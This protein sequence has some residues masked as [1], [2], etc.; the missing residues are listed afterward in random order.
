MATIIGG[1]GNGTLNSSLYTLN[2]NDTTGAGSAGNGEQVY[3]NVTNGN[4]VIDHLDQFLPSETNNFLTLRTYNSRGQFATPDGEGWDLTEF[5]RLSVITPGQVVLTNGDGSQFNFFFDPSS[6]VY[7]STDGAGA[8]E[9]LSFNPRNGTYSVVLSNQTVVTYDFTGRLIQSK[10]TNGNTITY[11][12]NFGGQLTSIADNDGHQLSFIYNFLGQLTKIQDETNT[13]FASYQYSGNELTSV[14]DRAGATTHY[15]YWPDGTLR[16]VTL[17]STAGEAQ[18]TLQFTYFI[19]PGGPVIASFTDA[20]GN[21]TRFNYDFNVDI[22]GGIEGGTTFVTNAAGKVTAYSFDVNGNITD[23]QDAQGLDTVYGYDSNNNLTTVIDANGSGIVRSDSAYYRN[24]R[25]SFGVVDASGQ[26]KLVWQLTFADIRN[27]QAHFTTHLTYDNNGNLTSQTDASG[28]LTTYTYTGFNK[29]ASST[30]AEGNALLTSNDPLSV[31]KRQEL[32]FV[33]PATGLGKSVAQLTTADRQAIRALYTTVYSYD[34]HQNLTQIK[35]AGGDLT[36]LTYDAFGNLSTKTVYLDSTNLTDP[37]KQETTQYFYDAFGNNIKTIDAQGNT[38][39]STFDHF[40]NKLTQVD[41]NGGVTRNTYDNENRLT[42]TTDPL[43]NTT[44]NFY[45]AVGNRIA[46]Q[47]ASGHTVTY[48]Y[49]SDNLLISTIDPSA[50]ASQAVTRT[51]VTNYAYDVM[52]N[53]TSSTDANGNTTTY[54]YDALNRMVTVTTPRVANAAGNSVNYTTSYAYDGVGNR[55]SVIDNNGNRTDTVYNSNNLVRQVTDASGNITQFAYDADLNQ[56]SIVVGAQLGATARQILKFDYD[57]KDRLISDTDALGNTNRIA[58]D[59]ANNRVS[60]TDANGNTTNYTYDRDNR[61]LTETKPAVA[62]P[63]TGQP[64]RYTIQHQY[65]A[66]GNQIAVTDQDGHT[67]RMSFD[68]DNRAVLVQ[69]ANGIQTVYTFDSRGNR[70][71]VQVGVQAHVSAAGTVVVDSTQSAQVETFTYDEFNQIVSK[72]D[73][74]GN[75]LISSDSALYVQM[76]Q[77]LGVVDPATGKG[78]LVAQLTAADIQTLKAQFTEVYTYDRV[79]NYTSTTDHLGRTTSLTYDALN[80]LVK[81]TDA[82]GQT[83]KTAFD[84]D[85]NVVSRTDALGRKT[86]NAYDS[87][88]RLV[89]T[90]DALGV[91][92][93]RTYD[94]FGN[95]TSTTAANGTPDARTTRYVYDLDNRLIANTDALGN[96]QTYSYDAVGNRLKVTDAKGQTTRYVYDALNRNIAIIDPLGLQTRFVY[97]GVGNRLSLVDAKGGIT[98]FTY[99]AG[100]R[101]IQMTDAMGRVTTFAYDVRGN[102]ISQT[103]ASGTSAQETTTYL[104]DAENHLRQVTDAAGGVTLEGY[105]ADY[106]RTSV[107]DAN[108]H[109]TS[110]KF[111]ALNREIQVTDATGAVTKYSYDAVG[112]RLSVTDGNGHVTTYAYDARNELISATDATGVVTTYAYDSVGNQVRITRAANTSAAAT[113]TFAYDLDNRLTAQTDAVGDTQT[114]RYDADGNLVAT[115][116]AL[117]HATTYA[118][119]A[120]NRVTSITDP[121]GNVTQYRYDA[122]GNRVQVIDARGFVSTNYYDADNEVALSVDNDG[123]A[124]SF[125]YDANGNII[126][127]TLYATALTLPLDPA[128]QPTPVTSS[129]LDQ[130]TL[131]AYDQLNRL[132]SRTDGDGFVT[133]Y[134]Y[135]A[136]GNRIATRQALDLAGTQFEVTRAFYDAVNREVASVTAQGYLTT[137]SYDAAGNRVSQTQ[138][139]QIVSVPANGGVPQPVSGDT[140]RTTTFAYDA[141]N[142]LVRQTDALGVV[143]TYQYDA[144][145]N[146]VAMTL[147]AGTAAAATTTYRY[148]AA[149]RNIETTNALGVVTHFDLDANGNVLKRH[150]AYG[151]AQE[152]VSSFQYDANNRVISTTDPL[153][154]VTR[155]A[156][157]S[158]GNLVSRTVGNGTATAETTTYSYDGDERQVSTTD[159]AG[160]A[161]AAVYNAAGEQVQVTQAVGL[162]DARTTSF[163]YDRANRLVSTT[164]AVG[165]VTQYQYDGAGNQVLV[166]QAAGTTQQRQSSFAYDLDNRLVQTTDPMGGVTQ[167]QYNA[168]GNQTRV[169]DANGGVQVNTFDAMGRELSSLS[170]GGILTRNTYDQ[171]GNLVSTTQSL[172]DGSDART[173][174]FVYDALN[175]QIQA[176]DGGGF[177][178]SFVYDAFGNRTSMTDARGNTTAY[179]YDADNRLVSMTDALGN[180]TSYQY[181]AIGNRIRTTD[182]NG[183]STSYAYDLLN[184]LVQTT[185]ADGGVTRYTYDHVGNRIAQDQQQSGSVFEHTSYQY[186]ADGRLISQTDPVGSVTQYTYDAVGN[187]LSQTS[188]AGTSAARTVH[189]EYDLD[190][191]KIA[192]VDALGNRTTYAYDAVGNRIS[193]TDPLGHVTHNYYDGANRL[194]EAVDPLGFI[195]SYAYDAASN[196]IRTDVYMTAVSGSIDARVPPSPPAGSPDQVTTQQYDRADRL[197]SQ[198]AADGTVTRYTYDAVGNRTSMTDARGNTTSYAY[199]ADNRLVTQTDATGAVT[200]YTYDAVGNRLSVT[201]A[202]GHV[203]ASTYD[204]WNKLISSTDANGVVTTYAYDLLGNQVQVTRAAG[205]SAAS[206]KTYA[207]DLDNRLVSQTDALGDTQT[208][209]Y[210]AAG[211]LVA[212]TDAL[213]HTTTYTYDANGQV[214][215]V[216]DPVGNVTQYRYDAAGNRA[217][218]IDAR[219]FVSTSYYNA[220]NELVLSVDNAG[221]ATGYV[222][223]ANGNVLSSTLYATALTLPLNPAVQPTPVTSASSDQT[224]LFAYDPLN[225][226]V[227]RTDGDGFVTQYVYD[228]VGNRIATRQALDLAATQF[229]VTRAYYDAVNRE[230][231]SVTAQGYLTTY[232]YDAA[233]NRVSQT[234]CDQ[235]VSVPANGSVPQ[236][237]SGD[238]GRTTTFAYDADNRLVQQTDALGVVTTYQYDARGNRISMTQ[239]AG[240]SQAATTTYRY[241]AADRYIETTN[242]LGVVT[243]FDLDANGNVLK[244]HDAYGT[245]QERVSS[246]QYDA[247]NR[248]VSQTDPRNVATKTTYDGDGNVVSTTV[249]VGTASAETTAFAYDGDNREIATT[250]AT[251]GTTTYAYDAAGNQVRI[252]QTT[253]LGESRTNT[254]VYDRWNRLISA[255]DAVGTVTQ[256]QYDGAGNKILTTQA[257]GTAQQRQ[258]FYAYD[259]DNRL[260]QVTDPMGGVTHY[261]YDAQGN[262]TRIVDAN[263]GVQINTFDAMGHVLSS[264]SAGGILTRNTVDLRGN[265][266]STTQSLADGSDARTSTYAYDAL[267]QQVEVTDGEGFSTSIGYDAF[268]NQVSITHGQYLVSPSDPAYSATKAAQAFPQTSTFTYDARNHMLSMTD[269]L[270]NVT[271]YQYD[272]IGNRISTTDAN[273]HTT[274]YAYDSLNRLVQTTTPAGGVTRYAYDHVG[275]K[276]DQYQLQSGDPASGVWEHTSYQYDSNGHVTGQTDPTGSVTQFQYDALGNQLSK[277]SAAGTSDARTV[278]MEYDLDNRKTADVDALGNRTTYAYDAV[279]NRIKVTDALG[280]VAHYY[281]DGADQLT[282]LVDAQGNVNTFAYD[283]AGNQVQTRVYMTAF[284]GSISEGV[285]PAPAA[286]SQDRITTQQYDRANRLVAQTAADGSL[287]QYAYDAAGNKVSEIQFANT[288]APRTLRFAYDADDRLVTFTDVDGSVTTFTYDKANN[289]TSQTITSASDPNHLRTTTYAYDADNHEQSETFDPSKLALTQSFAYDRL[290]NVTSKTD[291]DGHTTTLAYDLNNRVVSQ[292]DPLGNTTTFTYDRVGNKIAVTDARQNTTNFVYD[293]NNRL[294]EAIL[295]AVQIFTVSGGSQTVRPTTLHTYDANGNEVRT[296]VGSYTTLVNG[297][298][299]TVSGNVTTRYFDGNNRLIG[300]VDATNAFTTYTYDAAGDKTSQTLYMTRLGASADPSTLPSAPA[301]DTQLITYAYDLMG[302]LTLTTYPAAKITTLINANTSNPSTTTVTKQVTERNVYDAFGNLV[303]A[304]D[305]NGNA[306]LVYY[307]VK[308]RKIAVVDGAG[309]LSEWDYDEQGNV[310]EQR[311]YTQP[312][313]ISTLQAGGTPPTPPSG[314]VYTTDFQYDAASRK[315][316]ETDPQIATFDPNS[317]TTTQL[318]PTT[319]YTYDKVGN[320]LTKTLG[321]G[322]AQAVTEYSYYDADNRQIATIDSGRVLSI[323]SYDASGNVVAQRRYFNPVGSG[324]DLTQLNGTTN[325]AALVSADSNRDEETEFAFDA[326]NRATQQSDLLSSGTL[327]K[328]FG[329]DAVS[330]RTYTQDEDHFI[331]RASFDGMNRLVESISADNSGTQYEYDAAG[332]RV[333]AY[334]GVF[335]GG[336]PA[337]AQ[338]SSASLGS[339]VQVTWTT[340]ATTTSPLQTWVVYD[341]SSHQGLSG[342]ANRTAAQVS[343]N[344]QSLTAALN[345]AGTSGTIYFRVVTVDGAGNET[346]TEEQSLSVPPRF[347]AVSVSQPDASTIVVTAHFDAGAVSPQLVYGTSGHLSQSVAFVLQSDGSYQVTLSGLSNPGDLSF[348]LKW[349]D[350]A[351]NEYLSSVSSFA[352]VADQ[353]A[354]SSTISQS[355]IVSGSNTSYT[356]SVS[357]QVPAGYAAGLTSMQAKWRSGNGVFA[358]T[359]VSGTSSGQ[360]TVIFNAV[361]G[362][363]NNLAPGTYEIVLTGVR[364]DGTTVEL[365]HFTY[366]VSPTA[367]TVTRHAVSWIA[368][369][370]GNDQLVIIDGQNAPSTRDG[371]RVVATDGVTGASNDYAAYYGQD[372]SDSHTVDVTS[373]AHTTSSPDPKNP[374]GPPIVTTTGYDV[375]VQATLSAGELANIGSGGLHLAWRPAGSGT[376]FSNDSALTGSGNT[377]STTLGN[378][379]AGQYD[380]KIYYVDAQGHQVIVEWQRIDTAAANNVYSGHSLTILA[381]ETGGTI[382]TDA[383]GVIALHPGVYTGALNV[384]ALSSALS[385]VHTKTGQAGGSLTTDGRDTGYFTQYEYNAL[386]EKTASNEGDGLWRTFGVDGNGNVVETDLRGDH[387]NTNAIVTYTAYDARNRKVADFGAPVVGPDGTT[388]VRPVTRYAYNVQDKV[389][390][391]TDALN[392]TTRYVY[393]AL[394]TQIET[395]D[396]YG[397]TT[398]TLVDQFGNVT[399]TVT[400]LGHRSLKFYDLQGRLVKEQ[401]AMGNATTYTYDAFGRRLT[402]T[403]A[404]GNTSSYTYDQRDR[405]TS[406]TDP[407]NNTESFAY[408]GRNNRISTLYP[409]GQRTDQ[410]YD[411]LGRVIDT[412]VYLNGQQAHSQ[413]AYDAYGNLISETDA[414]LR[415]KTHVYGAFG[416]LMEDIDEDGNVIAYNYDVYGRK[417]RSFDPSGGKDIQTTYNQ[418]GQITSVTDLA[419]HVSTTYTYDLLGHR[420]SE[421][422]TTPVADADRNTTYEYDALG[423]L[424]RW[425]DS[426][427]HDNLNTQFDAEGNVAR[428]YTDNGYDPLSQNPDAN[429]N[430][431]YVDH[432]YTYDADRRLVQEVQRTT[433]ASGNT[434]DSILN[435]Y[436]YDAAS[437][438]STWNHDS[439]VVTYTYDA[440]GRVQEGDYYTGSDLNQQQW[441]YDAMGNVLTYTTLKDGALQTQTVNTYN[442]ENRS[443]TSSSTSDGKTQVTT[444]TYDLTMRITQTVLQNAGKTYTYNYSYYGDG[445][446]ASVTAFGDAKGTTVSTYDVNKVQTG[447]NLGQGDGQD[448]PE[449]KSFIA[450]NDGHIIYEIHD[451]GKKGDP[452]EHDQFLYANDNPVGQNVQ[453]TDGKLTVQLD[454]DSYAPVQ[455]LSDSNPGS[456]LTYTVGNGDTLQSIASTMY[457]NASLWF[458]IAEA[459]GLSAGDT[460]KAGTQLLIPNTIQSGTITANNHKVYSATDIVGSTLP[461]L[462]SPPPPHHG[463]CASILAIIIIVVIAVVVSIFVPGL[464]AVIAQAAGG[465]LGGVSGAAAT[466]LAVA[467]DVVAGAVLGAIGSIVQQGL[468]IAIGYQQKFSWKEVAHAAE[469]E[470][471]QAGANDLGQI[472]LSAIN[473]AVEAEKIS[474]TVAKVADAAVKVSIAAGTQLVENGKITSWTGVA[475]AGLNGYLGSGVSTSVTDAISYVTPWVGLAEKAIRNGK[476]TPTDWASAV[477]DTV[478]QALVNNV[479]GAT[480][481]SFT[482]RLESAALKLGTTA[483]VSGALSHYD[484]NAAESYFDNSVGQEVGDFIGGGI[485]SWANQN[486]NQQT[487]LDMTM[488]ASSAARAKQAPTQGAQ[489]SSGLAPAIGGAVGTGGST[490]GQSSGELMTF[491]S[492][493]Y[494]NT[495]LDQLT[496]ESLGSETLPDVLAEAPSNGGT[497]PA[498]T[499]AAAPEP[500]TFTAGAGAARGFWGIA[501]QR[502]GPGASNADILRLDEQLITANPGVTTIHAGDTLNLPASTIS[503]EAQQTYNSM[504]ASYQADLARRREAAAAAAAAAQQQPTFSGD[505]GLAQQTG[506]SM[507]QIAALRANGIDPTAL[508]NSGFGTSSAPVFQTSNAPADQTV[509]AT[510]TAP[511]ATGGNWFSKLYN[512]TTAYV[513]GQ[514][515]AFQQQGFAGTD[516]GK[517]QLASDKFVSQVGG[518]IDAEVNQLGQWVSGVRAQLPQAGAELSDLLNLDQGGTARS[519]VTWVGNNAGSTASSNIGFTQGAVGSLYDTGKSVLNLAYGASQLTNPWEWAANPQ[520]NLDRINTTVSTVETVAKIADLASPTSWA[521]DPNGNAQLAKA[522]WNSTSTSFQNDP[523]KFLGNAVVT[524]G[525]FFIPG[526]GEADAAKVLGGATKATEVV[527]DASKVIKA[528]DEVIPVAQNLAAEATSHAAPI[529]ETA[530]GTPAKF[531]SDSN[532]FLDRAVAAGNM[533][534]RPVFDAVLAHPDTQLVLPDLIEAEIKPTTSQLS[535]LTD[536]ASKIERTTTDVSDILSSNPNILSARFGTADL[537]LLETARATGLPVV[538]SNSALVGQVA[539]NAARS[540][541]FGEVPILVPFKHFSTADELVR[542][543]RSLQ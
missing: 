10:D 436:T 224:T 17:P 462:K 69:D 230:V 307:D 264:L 441:T 112:N 27:L 156:Y 85:G 33:D 76:R 301:G 102:R 319:T 288:S 4:L 45:D 424:V 231:A 25:Q 402:S 287:T 322:T 460:L 3:I 376:D 21:V 470:A 522:L 53:R 243:H 480:D 192:D 537:Q 378:L 309:Y 345:S 116:D 466:A 113:T 80:R 96:T 238:K 262:Q 384:G 393:N 447:L 244:R 150:D 431:R 268:G 323:Y 259:L 370:V 232:T 51:R 403:D 524:V 20:Q 22:F 510:S 358:Q 79:G 186:D 131:F 399:A 137:Y 223:D 475:A 190:N 296:E 199:D 99:D 38:T 14:T 222:Y 151:T 519:V 366:V 267:N 49:N 520:A 60:A 404:L 355:Q 386:N 275:N 312:L 270:G 273:G 412:I 360:G 536:A 123:Y 487:A 171:R 23:V 183:H 54:T 391:Q 416:R 387:D 279:G 11:N 202:N 371:G 15:T 446:E 239:A 335:T 104:Y 207:Y 314:E 91:D 107:T 125:S 187:V 543:I 356:L 185:T 523:S 215:S 503:A 95:L 440:D 50:V 8:Y 115:T 13:V 73:G 415:T 161:T 477:G 108:G 195:K 465:L 401:D 381:Q 257:V 445:R 217:Q 534:A 443:L 177:K 502:L 253:G 281:Y 252:T 158:A 147:A 326:L 511:P 143:T 106:N 61:L 246:F 282:E 194:I 39:L 538:T 266:V 530:G 157:D 390:A 178:T 285:P 353:V 248:V 84:G 135:D 533:D 47:D 193:V 176:T 394:G 531:V 126:S 66:N 94:S 219:G 1:D 458:V 479:P 341:T 64:V 329:Y 374:S 349:D 204:A 340:A 18:R 293:A 418:A 337:P 117:G 423:Q 472:A 68:K 452:I 263:G 122:N 542:L 420:L 2:R 97:D 213:G 529:L 413:G 464:G 138:Y 120:D 362:D 444:T 196:L 295:P 411:G 140:G 105:D 52:G 516:L 333:L 180:V 506:L 419:T 16:S 291:A 428:V 166:V 364:A 414:M 229:E 327:S 491:N 159:A 43:G 330:N 197:I 463:G 478:G 90:V 318:R 154:I 354:V 535:R 42:S 512:S 93:H 461:N 63:V 148:D 409:L 165:T 541:L 145:G 504:D 62:D 26:G 59:G 118:Y 111:D 203:T 81:T 302:R 435:A 528:A 515:S 83:I 226:L 65:D 210:D 46:V 459:N 297:V 334:T 44:V 303:Q 170:A 211:N 19:G 324:V 209:Q 127:Q 310:L 72:T 28:N 179:A 70:T 469:N 198:T 379:P 168:Q 142:R 234:Q 283:A 57:Q 499:E 304:F 240:T 482:G 153:G 481:D 383:Q 473:D 294:I 208:R 489:P 495:E 162:A 9:T 328:E 258:T 77:Q 249:A 348:Q 212:T 237:V 109:T 129:S 12:Y 316:K 225:R 398:Q 216:T 188:A 456:N 521:I 101:E 395:I 350:G 320:Q 339:Q 471:I 449:T 433:D 98:K 172:A 483:L 134:V 508:A 450:D 467:S 427:T 468:L 82:L 343:L 492:E 375:G 315:V 227:S 421:V 87:V 164:D 242:A 425:S 278:H 167:Y 474:T 490:S 247:D 6:G 206:T 457:G 260:I 388:L 35:S 298:P 331:T 88:N 488:A 74:V 325:F 451:D 517:L 485:R 277:T 513:S 311:V 100:N 241:D 265:V 484:R 114:H 505:L 184:R 526:A 67:T 119:D 527:Q 501:K 434:S 438:K 155:M 347:S 377:F 233:G 132:V 396:P 494:H 400:Q 256:Y 128:V 175:Q 410:V 189:M 351:G 300:Q 359:A 220:D 368:P 321:A 429:P 496:L 455:N 236:P 174:T 250:D 453:G 56:V 31:A 214:T 373:T 124:K 299:T 163:V 432:V 152:R 228:A 29:V 34:A 48:I 276:T 397:Q 251:G 144:R 205:T 292:T 332:N 245:A 454:S 173:L 149:D 181:D 7:R 518:S 286:S 497:E 289:K 5:S 110:V 389:T 235:I 261:Q 24:L 406:E 498:N 280:H 306:T 367:T 254:F 75:A 408:D 200:R 141:D 313:D 493:G 369:A 442:D 71:S 509:S 89:D 305:K 86:I 407:L 382:V 514:V 255:T 357:T 361:L 160:T 92:T 385:L 422:I 36:R 439:V 133:Q 201:D 437:N 55:I 344:G 500:T 392:N 269:A 346:W 37:S 218:V 121:L 540:A 363:P 284:M 221:Y 380:L 30:S 317:Q 448:R 342:Y 352:D 40:G 191:R 476:V 139:D 58:Y 169:V 539:N 182:A 372:F 136:V 146:R 32:G 272:A 430:F 532:L 41:G 290:G 336:A 507:D 130:T 426:V 103:T 338:I 417:T 525:S 486:V 308:G 271:S 274:S 365:D 78:K 405:I